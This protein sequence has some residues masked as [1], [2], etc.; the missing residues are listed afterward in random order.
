MAKKKGKTSKHW[1]GVYVDL[2]MNGN[3]TK[4]MA[5]YELYIGLVGPEKDNKKAKKNTKK[6]ARF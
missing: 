1:E 4:P 5:N 6:K 2:V 3:Y